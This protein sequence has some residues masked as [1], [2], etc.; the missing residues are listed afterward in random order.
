MLTAHALKSRPDRAPWA[1]SLF[2]TP[3]SKL[4]TQKDKTKMTTTTADDELERRA[5]H[6][7]K[8][9]AR[10]RFVQLDETT[11]RRLASL[12]RGCEATQPGN[13]SNLFD[14]TLE[15]LTDIHGLNLLRPKP[16]EPRK[17]PEPFKDPV[18]GQPCENPWKTGN[19]RDQRAIT[20]AHPELAR[21][22]R[23][24]A[25]EPNAYAVELAEEEEARLAEIKR[26]AEYTA[27]VHA[28]NVFVR[29]THTDQ[30]GFAAALKAILPEA[31]ADAVVKL[32]QRE[33]KPMDISALFAKAGETGQ[34]VLNQIASQDRILFDVVKGAQEREQWIERARFE[35]AERQRAE[36]AVAA[37][38]QARARVEQMKGI[39]RYPDGRIV[40][41]PFARS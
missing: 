11:R 41:Q 17:L 13:V 4:Q 35:V 24:A 23:R 34:G 9:H 22:L 32:Y 6:A 5:V 21:H 8:N 2:P 27:D 20:K 14:E 40:T 7:W 38:R 30:H 19:V 36:D 25:E 31:E 39:R 33:A 37:E 3:E 12:L 10:A 26:E 1:A 18:T 28:K 15:K 29:G 16:R